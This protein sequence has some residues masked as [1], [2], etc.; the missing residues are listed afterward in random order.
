MRLRF[1]ILCAVTVLAAAAPAFAGDTPIQ[2]GYWEAQTSWLGISTSTEH[3]CVK[4]KDV[5]KFLSGPSNHIYHC[6]YPV[7]TAGAGAIHF[8]GTC[9]DKH[10]QEVKLKG[11]GRYTPT[12]VHMTASGST[13]L[14]GL[15]VQGE[16]SVDA[17]F[18]SADCPADARNFS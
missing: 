1:P 12:T 14:L 11:D 18:V 9:V 4:P 15:Q 8:D 13:S 7:S 17:H 3:W 16:A 2:T 5:S 10:G 6:T